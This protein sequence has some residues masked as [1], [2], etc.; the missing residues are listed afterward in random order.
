MRHLPECPASEDAYYYTLPF[1]KVRLADL[2][3]GV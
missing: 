3:H 1:V 2:N